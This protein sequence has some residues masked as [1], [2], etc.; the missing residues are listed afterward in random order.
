MLFG[1]YPVSH[2]PLAPSKSF[3][4][5]VSFASFA[6]SFSAAFNHLGQSWNIGRKFIAAACWPDLVSESYKNS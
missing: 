3:L 6:L 5:I 1:D 4:N 2:S